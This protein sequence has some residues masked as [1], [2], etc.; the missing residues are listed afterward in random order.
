MIVRLSFNFVAILLAILLG[1][2]FPHYIL[3]WIGFLM[4]F[5]F[6]AFYPTYMGLSVLA[7]TVFVVMVWPTGTVFE[8]SSG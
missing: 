1:L 7:M 3:L 2:I 5:F 6:R 4:L 8:N